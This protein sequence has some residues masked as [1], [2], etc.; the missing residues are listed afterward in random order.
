MRDS[1]GRLEQQQA[2]R[3]LLQIDARHAWARWRVDEH[4][5]AAA[6]SD[7]LVILARVE[8]VRGQ[9]ESAAPL[10]TSVARGAVAAAPCEYSR[11]VPAKAERPLHL[12]VLDPN[13]G[14]GGVSFYGRGNGHGPISQRE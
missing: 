8:R 3:R 12:R 7:P 14:C 11:Y 6:F 10:H 9:L 2:L 13:G 5:I 4:L 1:H